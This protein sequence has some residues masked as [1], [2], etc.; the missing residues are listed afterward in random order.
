MP[1]FSLYEHTILLCISGSQSYGMATEHSDVDLKGVCIPPVDYLLG[2][3][4]DFA[5]YD[6]PQGLSVFLPFIPKRLHVAAQKNKLEGSIYGLKK[7]LRLAAAANPNIIEGLFCREEDIVICTQ[8]GRLLRTNRDLFISA[9]A[10]HTFQGYALAQLKRIQTH[11]RWL[12]NPPKKKPE[13]SDFS[14]PVKP[15]AQL[16]EI[17]HHIRKQLD[18]WEWDLSLCDD[19][20]VLGIRERLSMQLAEMKI[21]EEERW[22][23]A[24]RFVGAKEDLISILVAEKK[25][26]HSHNQWRQ[27]QQWL[28]NRNP[29]RAELEAKHGYDTKHAAHL[30]RLMRMGAEILKTGQCRVWRG[31]IDA[32]EL[33]SIRAGAW[34]YEDLITWAEE[35]QAELDFI[36]KERAYSIPNKPDIE[37][38]NEL[39][40]NICTQWIEIWK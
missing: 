15:M 2:Y 27:Y 38:I 24:A 22:I 18:R 28:G 21:S 40:V 10:R 30:V 6:K 12:L 11:R 1:P 19:A 5:Q 32:Q 37:K 7:F 4:N 9:Q 17:R 39:C 13:R 36:F 35:K 8:L 26:S 23:R 34:R 25:Y 31:D 3:Q 29:K 16:Q 14:L 20:E 33:L